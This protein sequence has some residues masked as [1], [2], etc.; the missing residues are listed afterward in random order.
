MKQGELFIFHIKMHVD[1]RVIPNTMAAK[2][3]K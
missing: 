2:S 3:K 1:P